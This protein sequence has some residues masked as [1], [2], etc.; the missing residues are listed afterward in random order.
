MN[1]C[2]LNSCNFQNA[3]HFSKY[4]NAW[5]TRLIK[6]MGTPNILSGIEG[7]MSERIISRSISS[8]FQ[9]LTMLSWRPAS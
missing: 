5:R 2:V 8:G 3:G 4:L 9:M 6:G 1:S 7:P